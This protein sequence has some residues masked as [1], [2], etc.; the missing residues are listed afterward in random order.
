MW[1]F[2]PDLLCFQQCFGVKQVSLAKYY[3]VRIWWLFFYDLPKLKENLIIPKKSFSYKWNVK[4]P[5][6]LDLLY[7]VLVLKYIF[8]KIFTF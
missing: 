5:E 1:I 7:N 8:Q 3:L 6:M 2:N 4:S